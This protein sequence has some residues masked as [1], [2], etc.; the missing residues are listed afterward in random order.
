LEFEFYL[1]LG[2]YSPTRNDTDNLQPIA[3]PHFAPCEFRR[4]NGFA[5]KFHNNTP[6]QKILRA[7]KLFYAARKIGSDRL[8]IRN[9]CRRSHHVNVRKLTSGGQ[10]MRIP[11]TLPMPWVM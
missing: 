4:R 8:A 1:E 7:E 2:A 11:N 9:D 6:R 10:L 3:I 5:I